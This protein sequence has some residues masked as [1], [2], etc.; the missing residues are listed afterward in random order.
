LSNCSFNERLLKSLPGHGAMNYSTHESEFNRRTLHR[1]LVRVAS[2]YYLDNMSQQDIAHS[3]GLSRPKV[4]RLLDQARREGIVE[5]R[6]HAFPSMHLELEAQLKSTFGLTEAVVA[7]SHPDAAAQLESVA[8]AA[9]DYLQ[10]HLRDGMVVAVG[11]GRDTGAVP[12]YFNP[13]RNIECTFVSAMGGSPR[14]DAPTNPNEICRALAVRCGGRAESLYAP[15]YVESAAMRDMLMQ[16][17]AVH[18]TLELAARADLAL[19]GIG[20]T[21]DECT[22]VRSGC[23]SLEQIRQL[24]AEMLVGDILA[25]YFDINGNLMISSLYGRLVGL[26]MDELRN[27]GTLIAVV[28]EVSKTRAILGALRAGAIDVLAV[29]ANNAQAVLELAGVETRSDGHAL[30]FP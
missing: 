3:L 9:A 7:P 4:Q 29:D 26:T 8:R 16:Q 10:R 23:L 5:I 25:N 1:L 28:S 30:P 6:I 14:L 22:M 27:I 11:M 19:V 21:N 24:R 20:S 15:A 12:K 17:E 13:H 2:L 18:H